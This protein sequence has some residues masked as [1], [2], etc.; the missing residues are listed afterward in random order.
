[1]YPVAGISEL[2]NV[3]CIGDPRTLETNSRAPY[4]AEIRD[5]VHFLTDELPG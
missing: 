3:S 4:Y 1:M 5:S 2:S